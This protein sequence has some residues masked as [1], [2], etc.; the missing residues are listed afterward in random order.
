MR[1]IDLLIEANGIFLSD[2]LGIGMM[3]QRGLR[4]GYGLDRANSVIT[5]V[6]G[7]DHAVTLETQAH[8]YTPGIAMPARSPL[9]SAANTGTPM[10]ENPSAS[11]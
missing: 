8:F 9:I 1:E 7:N 2:M 5:A 6:R 3:L 4:Q 11:T 10:A